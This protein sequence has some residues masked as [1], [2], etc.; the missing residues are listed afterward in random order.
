MASARHL[1]TS[2]LGRVTRHYC[3]PLASFDFRTAF[4]GGIPESMQVV[5]CN[6]RPGTLSRSSASSESRLAGLQ[7]WY[8]QKNTDDPSG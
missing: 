3:T 7:T 5:L 4:G 1:E 8:V 2:C 6:R